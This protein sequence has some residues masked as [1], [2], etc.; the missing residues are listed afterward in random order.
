MDHPLTS[1]HGRR[2]PAAGTGRVSAELARLMPRDRWLLDLLD[3]HQVLTTEQITMLCY[4]SRH[5][6]RYRLRQLHRR[7]VLDRFRH[8]SR[9]GSDTYR[10]TLGPVGAAI[11][12]TAAGKP[13]PRPQQVRAH[14]DRLATSPKLSHL[15][16]VNELFC[17]LAAHARDRAG[18]ALARWWSER[19]ATAAAGNLVRPDGAGTWTADRS[20]VS[21]WVE[22][23][24]GTEQLSRLTSKLH[25]GYTRLAGT[26]L[27]WPVLFWLPN[28]ARE[29]HLHDMLASQGTG[30]VTVATAT[31]VHGH[32]AGPVWRLAGRPGTARL[33]LHQLPTSNDIE[34]DV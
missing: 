25:N 31:P 6:A 30:G 1:D 28:P 13:P 19:Q 27:A 34:E 24:R 16:A 12:A 15:I 3:Q 23:D 29:D 17:T 22:V 14:V 32:P 10:W 18:L 7:E 5:R 20:T 4:P 33:A 2:R 26:R 21:F 9:P 8:A 11:T